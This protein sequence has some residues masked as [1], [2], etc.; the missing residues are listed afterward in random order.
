MAEHGT[1]DLS[2]SQAPVH[3]GI[4]SKIG[5][6]HHQP[7]RSAFIPDAT[8]KAASGA[9]GKA[10]KFAPK[11]PFKTNRGRGLTR[12]SLILCIATT[13]DGHE[14]SGFLGTR[15]SIR[16]DPCKSVAKVLIAVGWQAE[17]SHSSGGIPPSGR[18][19]PLGGR[20]RRRQY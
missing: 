2:S 3:S 6:R 5:C 13:Q 8:G 16:V 10:E 4:G 11:F 17:R 12:S 9:R 20:I 18:N 14:F 1:P 15:A 19:G 7:C